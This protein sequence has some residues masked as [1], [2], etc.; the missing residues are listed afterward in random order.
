MVGGLQAN[1][2]AAAFVD[3]LRGTASPTYIAQ[4]ILKASNWVN[5]TKDW[6]VQQKRIEP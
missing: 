5:Y 4:T 1:N 3:S 2:E 6:S